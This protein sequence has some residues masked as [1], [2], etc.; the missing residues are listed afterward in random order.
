[1][2]L[3]KQFLIGAIAV[4]AV[5]L[6]VSSYIVLPGSGKPAGPSLKLT[7]VDRFVFKSF[8][9]CNMSEVW[10]GDK[11]M[12]FPGKYGEDPVWGPSNNLKYAT[13]STVDEAFRTAEK[14]FL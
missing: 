6:I 5:S 14:G 7:P 10:V 4:F 3:K 11:F 9:D 2:M 8:V 1:M 12:I 13:G